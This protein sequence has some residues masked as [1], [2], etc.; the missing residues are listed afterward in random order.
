MAA[1]LRQLPNPTAMPDWQV[2]YVGS[3]TQSIPI[4]N[5]VV[6]KYFDGFNG[7]SRLPDY[8]VQIIHTYGWYKSCDDANANAEH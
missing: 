8:S 5:A 4:H 1:A 2:V 7:P 3:S 6:V